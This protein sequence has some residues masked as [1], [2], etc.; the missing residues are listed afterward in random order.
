MP[1]LR[2]EHS[3]PA[4][5]READDLTNHPLWANCRHSTIEWLLQQSVRRNFSPRAVIALEK[6][7]AD[8]LHVVIKGSVE[9]FARYR[10]QETEFALIE[11]PHAFIVAAVILNRSNLTSARA[12]QPS[13]ILMI[14]AGVVREAF[15]RDEIFARRMANEL[16]HS[17][18]AVT[19]ELKSQTLLTAIERLANWLLD[20]DAET[21]GHHRFAIPFDKKALAA[22]LGMV[23]EVLSRAFAS[24]GKYDVRVRGA[25]VEIR[26]P[27]ALYRLA[28]PKPHFYDP[29]E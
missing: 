10:N 13:D 15:D 29:K 19:R 9:L 27:P 5:S 20:R 3:R 8:F 4:P 11:A 6:T 1:S 14:P 18:R 24:L 2:L 28:R 21:G 16:A 17:Y 7:P 26:D 25:T 22:R 12:L 23:P